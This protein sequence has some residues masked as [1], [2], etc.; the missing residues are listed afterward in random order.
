MLQS[1]QKPRP[2]DLAPGQT[3]AV[4]YRLPTRFSSTIVGTSVSP[5]LLIVF[6]VLI[7]GGSLLVLA[8]MPS[9]APA[10][11]RKFVEVGPGTSGTETV[12]KKQRKSDSTEVSAKRNQTY[13]YRGTLRAASKAPEA[14]VELTL[15]SGSEERPIW[16][17]R[18]GDFAFVV[19]PD[20]FPVRIM[21]GGGDLLY[22][23]EAAPQGHRLRLNLSRANPIPYHEGLLVGTGTSYERARGSATCVLRAY[24]TTRLPVDTPLV[25]RVL[26]GGDK[27]IEETLFDYAGTSV[28]GQIE[29]NAQDLY[30]G[31]YRLRL[32]WRTFSADSE[33]LAEF[34]SVL[35]DPMPGEVPERFRLPAYFGLR[36]DEAAQE[37][38]IQD[39]YRAAMLECALSRDLVLWIGSE[40]RGADFEIAD[41]RAEE[42]RRHPALVAVRGVGTRGKFRLARWRKLIDE[43]LPTIWRLHSDPSKIPYPEKYPAWKTNLL[44]AYEQL[45]KLTRLESRLIYKAVQETPDVRDY[46]DFDFPV[47]TEHFVTK[48]RLEEFLKQL[49]RGIRRGRG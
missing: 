21:N 25:V 30:S 31:W 48:E 9:E 45:A 33:V 47:P 22:Y 37:K 24:G 4:S 42:L 6:L 13:E 34:K 46:V 12:R 35:P 38:Q 43:E 20:G 29:C 3:A 23:A 1:P 27:I 28:I 2:R 32:A 11:K 36:E 5:R 26:G 49:R 17:D 40:V 15:L 16:T 8:M 10:P 44:L 7:V 41:E 18:D 19:Q 14:E 39:F